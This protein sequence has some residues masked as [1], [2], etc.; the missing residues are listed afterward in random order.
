M[1]LPLRD[2]R[3][4]ASF[5]SIIRSIRE[6]DERLSWPSE[7]LLT[8]SDRGA[9]FLNEPEG[10]EFINKLW[11]ESVQDVATVDPSLGSYA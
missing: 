2:P 10:E 1:L 4:M 8:I 9:A 3:S 11:K 7:C 6:C 5:C